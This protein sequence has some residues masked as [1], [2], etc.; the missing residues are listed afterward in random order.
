[1]RRL[2]LL[3]CLV[4]AVRAQDGDLSSLIDSVFRPPPSQPTAK[5]IPSNKPNPAPVPAKPNL[6][7]TNTGVNLCTTKEG[8]EGECV[9]YYLCNASNFIITDGV[10]IIDIRQ[11][12]DC[13]S[14]MDSCCLPPDKLSTPVP[15]PTQQP[16]AA[17]CGVRN[18]EGVGFR[19]KGDKDNEAQFGEF[20]WMVAIL[21][22]EA[23]AN[24]GNKLNV[25]QCGG[26][27]IH[28]QVVL[29]AAHCIPKATGSQP[30]PKL[31]I[32]A[33]EWDTQTKNE[34]YPHQD[35]GVAKIVSH[36][37]YYSGGLFNDVALL[38]LESPVNEADNVGVV[39]LPP[40]GPYA[41]QSLCVASGWGKDLFGKEGRY[42]VILKKVELPIVD[43]NRCQTALRKT[44]LGQH[45]ELHRSF[46]CAGGEI[47]KDVCKGDGGSPLVCPIPGNPD[48]YMQSGIVS[49]GIGCN[50]A[51]PGVYANIA[52]LRDWIDEQLQYNNIDMTT[53][54][55]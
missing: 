40:P 15:P 22:E 29:T 31:K 12:E 37:Q 52:L 2:L 27:L 21:R 19:I 50:E 45:F 7:P 16:R 30:A 54:Q 8:L 32:R 41:P 55:I 33:G 26:S 39:C 49:W 46:I 47:G 53:Y 28:P 17:G 38:F 4:L 51:N 3:A 10:G 5:P 44:R 36:Q 13:E 6:T 23:V 20:P 43:K 11:G 18:P 9:P 42:Q 14:Y 34:I 24:S 1:M 35:R 48:R 25:Y